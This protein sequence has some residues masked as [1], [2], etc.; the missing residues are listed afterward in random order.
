M[1]SMEKKSIQISEG[2]YW[3]G[4]HDHASGF[5]CNP[6]LL[7]DHDEAIL[8]DPGSVLDFQSVYENIKDII[9]IEKIKYV[10]LHH[11]DPD[12]CSSVPLFEK[13]GAKFTIITQWRTQTIIKFYGIRSDFYLV[14]EHNYSLTL[15]SGREIQFLPTPYLHF[16]G[17]IASY[18]TLTKTLFSSDLFGAISSTWDLFAKED[19]I[20]KMKTFHE[21][22]MP[23]ND[24]L[25]PVMEMFLLMDIRMIAPQHGSIINNEIQKHIKALREL[26]CGTFL[27]PV[28][29][30]I[31]KA[32][33]YAGICSIVIKRY[34]SIYSETDVREALEGLDIVTGDTIDEI[35]DYSY[36]G[37][38]LW[39]KLFE[40][41]YLKKGIKWLVVMEPLVKNL[42]KEYELPIP[43]VYKSELN[44]IHQESMMLKEELLELKD[45]NERLNRNIAQTQGKIMTCPVTGLYSEIFFKEYLKIDLENIFEEKD[46]GERGLLV[47]SVDN[48][49]RIRY[50]YGD[51]EADNIMKGIVYLLKELKIDQDFLFRLDGP[52]IACFF[53]NISK[54]SEIQFAERIRNTI[55]SSKIFIEEI[56]V[57]IGIVNLEELTKSNI[58]TEELPD[59]MYG[60]A[61]MRLRMAKSKGGNLVCSESDI[62]DYK[63]THGKIVIIDSDKT[64]Q[65]I[66][67]IFLQNLKYKVILASDGEEALSVVEKE[68]PDLI[69]SEIMLPKIDGFVLC[70]K[71]QQ[72]SSTKNI[73]FIIVSNLKNED[74][75]KRAIS[76]GIEHYFQ[77]PYML[78]ELMGIIQIRV[79]G[80]KA[81][82]D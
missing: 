64:N 43:R 34:A 69:V 50:L 1:M 23:S 62:N 67:K 2:I 72:Q 41:L 68:L 35:K 53:P 19:Y 52:S 14:D 5:Q 42:S 49:A 48:M 4:V 78:I 22:Y 61:M 60:I 12:L 36:S 47:L 28:K 10:V 29:K 46:K 37:L 3:V 16:P 57:S 26:E 70:E 38:E 51:S 71:L 73:P 80:E 45:I 20:E 21:H 75:V 44:S 81:N 58:A 18:D 31:K 7:I 65:D 66:L 76:L 17:A 9:H 13:A 79:K 27:N 56:S 25:R 55:R 32:G 77:K 8:F 82:E 63:Q 54:E 11:Q 40:N 59:R 6:Y 15:L 39:E 30:S 74:S 33:G 24:I